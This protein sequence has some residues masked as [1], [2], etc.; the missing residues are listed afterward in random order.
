[1]CQAC[2]G[3]ATEHMKDPANVKPA[4]PFNKLH[5]ALASEQ[6]QVCL[7]CHVGQRHLAFWESGKHAKQD[8]TCANCHIMHGTEKNP[9]IAPFTTSFRPNEADLCG[10]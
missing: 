1:M 9:P 10:T 4:N 5:P 3:D 7:N 8:V 6:S 2:H